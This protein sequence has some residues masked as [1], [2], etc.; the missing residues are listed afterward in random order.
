MNTLYEYRGDNKKK[1]KFDLKKHKDNTLYSLKEVE[2]FL[3][4]A[5]KAKNYS[6]LFKLFK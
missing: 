2:K 6:L 5:T 1:N 4:C 3:N